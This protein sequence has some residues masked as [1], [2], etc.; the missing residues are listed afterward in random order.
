MVGGWNLVLIERIKENLGSIII[1]FLVIEVKLN[2]VVVEITY[3]N[4]FVKN[5]AIFFRM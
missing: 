5:L 1:T 4:H 2:N 3:I